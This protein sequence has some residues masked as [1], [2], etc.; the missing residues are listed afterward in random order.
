MNKTIAYKHNNQSYT[1]N[2]SNPGKGGLHI[3]VNNC[4]CGFVQPEK[5]IENPDK[6]LGRSINRYNIEKTLNLIR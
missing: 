2:I 6:H 1:I 4:V 3:S 5:F